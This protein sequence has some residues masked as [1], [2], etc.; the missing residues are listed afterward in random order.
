MV[1]Q[2]KTV[3]FYT[4]I[5]VGLGTSL[6]ITPFISSALA[7]QPPIL[8]QEAVLRPAYGEH[9]FSG[10]AGQAVAITMTSQ[11]FD[12]VLS[13][14]NPEGLEIAYSNNY[15]PSRTS[16]LVAVLPVDGTYTVRTR[17][18]SGQEAGDYTVAVRDAS[19]YEAAYAE[20]LAF[21]YNGDYQAAVTAYDRAIAID[22]SQPE[23]YVSRAE[24]L[25]AIAQQ[26]R[27]EERDTI[28]TNYRRA[29]ELYE[30]TGNTEAAQRM[31]D[32]ISYLESAP[33]Y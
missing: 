22:G 7:D 2:L 4:A 26:L 16:T 29:L 24:V 30:Q 27:P 23:V 11:D 21:Y 8:R 3:G 28:L 31:R 18:L 19:P 5:A 12:T 25:Y 17:S 33:S 20:G 13:L 6:S 15:E 32:Q 1:I 10:K 14:V 9:Q